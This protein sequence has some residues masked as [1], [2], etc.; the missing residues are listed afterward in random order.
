MY[1]H[2]TAGLADL[3]WYYYVTLAYRSL[4]TFIR[5]SSWLNQLAHPICSKFWLAGTMWCPAIL[6]AHAGLPMLGKPV[7]WVPN[8]WLSPTLGHMLWESGWGHH[9]R[10]I[11]WKLTHRDWSHIM[12]RPGSDNDQFYSVRST[13][14]GKVRPRDI[15]ATSEHF[16]I[17]SFFFFCRDVWKNK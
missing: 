17:K 11:N 6:A 12:C 16:F 8:I 15:F 10:H 13:I 1:V 7:M 5:S 2:K 4:C 14:W 9:M 3:N